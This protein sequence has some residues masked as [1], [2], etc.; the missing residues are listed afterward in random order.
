MIMIR[1]VLIR[2]QNLASIKTCHCLFCGLF[3]VHF[4]NILVY[5]LHKQDEMNSQ[6]K[7]DEIKYVKYDFSQHN[8]KLD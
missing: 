6:H 5:S 8:D 1:K 4:L 7:Q 2:V 3:V